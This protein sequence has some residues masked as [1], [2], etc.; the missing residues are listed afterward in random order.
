MYARD[1]NSSSD[2]DDSDSYEVLFLAISCKDKPSEDEIGYL[3]DI[4]KITEVDF[5]GE[6]MC[7]QEEIDRLI[8]KNNMLKE[9]LKE[10][11]GSP[12]VVEEGDIMNLRW[13]IE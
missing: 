2:E 6:F 11:K 8:K 5:E 12:K 4:E 10:I 13:E 9:Q 1:D 3:E 7:A